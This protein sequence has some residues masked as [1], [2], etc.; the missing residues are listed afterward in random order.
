MTSTIQHNTFL[1]RQH[2]CE[3][4]SSE[5]ICDD[6]LVIFAGWNDLKTSSLESVQ[7]SEAEEASAHQD[8]SEASSSVEFSASKSSVDV[9]GAPAEETDSHNNSLNEWRTSLDASL[10]SSLK[11]ETRLWSIKKS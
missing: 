6:L 8:S 2:F 11:S 9:G 1:S 3:F 4:D 5:E 10:M 7:L